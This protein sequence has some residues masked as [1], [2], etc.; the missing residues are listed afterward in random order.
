MVCELTNIILGLQLL[1]MV[2][3]NTE[4]KGKKERL[5]SCGEE[6]Q[7]TVL[8]TANY[9]LVIYLNQFIVKLSA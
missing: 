7:L 9:D 2:H 8:V 1:I 3:V 5:G 4:S 6:E